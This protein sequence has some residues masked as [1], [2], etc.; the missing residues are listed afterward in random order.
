[1]FLGEVSRR[2]GPAHSGHEKPADAA[3]IGSCVI[4]SPLEILHNCRSSTGL[5]QTSK[6]GQNK[7]PFGLSPSTLARKKVD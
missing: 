4:Q 3:E 5:R 7:D 6:G 1:M 2:S